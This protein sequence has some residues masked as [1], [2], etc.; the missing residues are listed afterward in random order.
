MNEKELREIEVI[1]TAEDH[2]GDDWLVD[3]ILELLDEVR[4]WKGYPVPYREEG[5]EP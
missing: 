5:R 4:R 3:T 2:P 1:V